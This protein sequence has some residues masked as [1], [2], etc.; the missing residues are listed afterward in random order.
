MKKAAV[1]AVKEFVAKVLLKKYQ[2]GFSTS[3]PEILHVLP[4]NREESLAG[5]CE[6]YDRFGRFLELTG[7]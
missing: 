2:K 7:D 1:R 3:V 4:E 6:G 5:Q